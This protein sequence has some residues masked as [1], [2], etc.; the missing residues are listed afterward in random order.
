MAPLGRKERASLQRSSGWRPQSLQ[1]GYDVVVVG[2]GA[3][4][5]ATAWA[6]S[7]QDAAL[8][9]A[10]L[11]PTTVGATWDPAT[12]ARLHALR[13]PAELTSLVPRAAVRYR[14]WADE[15]GLE[16]P[17]VRG[18]HVV[19]A[20]TTAANVAL[21]AA[22]AQVP[23][24]RAVS[25]QERLELVFRH[26]PASSLGGW[27]EP[28]ATTMDLHD[29]VFRLAEA[30]AR[31]GVDLVDDAAVT[32][33]TA[34]A[35]GYRLATTAGPTEAAVVLDVDPSLA[36]SRAAGLTGTITAA[37]HQ[38][39]TTAAMAPL[40]GVSLT[41]DDVAVSQ[42]PSGEVD[43]IVPLAGPLQ[44]SGLAACASG[45]RKAVA[46]LP[47]LSAAAVIDRRSYHEAISLDGLPLI[48]ALAPR[49]WCA[50][51]LGRHRFDLLPLVAESLAG[52][53]VSGQLDATLAGFA[54]QR[55]LRGRAAVLPSAARLSCAVCGS[56]DRSEFVLVAGRLVHAGGC[57]RALG[58][59]SAEVVIDLRDRRGPAA[60]VAPDLASE[61]DGPPWRPAGADEPGDA[62]REPAVLAGATTAVGGDGHGRTPAP[63]DAA[64]PRPTRSSPPPA[65]RVER[66]TAAV[67]FSRP[68]RATP[69]G[70]P[71]ASRTAPD[72][73]PGGERG[74]DSEER[75]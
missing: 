6:L 22:A 60:P 34:T 32:A 69:P 68:A 36:V 62:G 51:G 35:T 39:L 23:S 64:R 25:V 54:P 67:P 45:A 40:L 48:G 7:V 58:G 13:V 38:R 71:A 47:A 61:Q 15:L 12:L 72:P 9:V 57:G 2:G 66:T 56:R 11:A 33:M 17:R 30:A 28:L 29:L 8:R 5:V 26:D 73:E 59:D 46:A 42:R 53:A 74:G 55:Q 14:A 18:G 75:P 44:A 50:G 10:V 16:P 4:A 1:G 3:L 21:R 43:L 31:A 70:R 20:T 52:A 24:C 65:T 27:H 49:L 19:L 41:I 37:S 63:A